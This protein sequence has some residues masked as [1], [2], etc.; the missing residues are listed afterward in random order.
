MKK[1]ILI[2]AAILL[3]CSCENNNP[4]TEV[5]DLLIKIGD[6]SVFEKATMGSYNW[7][8]DNDDG[9]ISSTI[10]CGMHPLQNENILTVQIDEKAEIILEFDKTVKSYSVLKYEVEENRFETG[11]GY[12]GNEISQNVETE[13]DSFT[14]FA[15]GK[16]Y[17]YVINAVYEKGSC[18][19]SFEINSS[20]V[21]MD[22]YKIVDG[23]QSGNLVLAGKNAGDVMTLNCKDISIYLDGK[24]SDI[25]ALKDG[26]T[27]EIYNDGTVLET[28]PGRF[29]KVD[30]ICAY[31]IGS[32]NEQGGVGFDLCGLYLEALRDIW[33]TDEGLNSGAEYVS[34]DLSEAPGALTDGEKSAIAWIF[35]NECKA[36]VL[37]YTYE[38]LIKEGYLD[39]IE[40]AEN[41]YEWKNGVLIKISASEESIS[42]D[43]IKF[44]IMKWRAPLGA[45]FFK[46]C[47]AIWKGQEKWEYSVGAFAI[48]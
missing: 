34:I 37:D 19:Y 27:V 5:P 31:S 1:F 32:E 45:N 41:L 6:S 46:D 22:M 30:Y 15:D 38:E 48:S 36:E 21:Y 33:K 14:V 42:E 16:S 20:E 13:E 9:T 24:E 26:M 12:T 28:Y 2:L 44:D 47:K 10:A 23:A 39:K 17:V 7:E 40:D 3:L 43:G 8:E 29:G 18:E 4:K 11:D 25:S 35:A